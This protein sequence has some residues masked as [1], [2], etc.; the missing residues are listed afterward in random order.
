M[1]IRLYTPS[2]YSQII[3][4]FRLNTPGYFSPD[5]EESLIEYL[6]NHI[7]YHYVAE[8]EGMIIGCGGYTVSKDG[9]TAHIAWDIVHP[10]SHGKGIGGNLTSLRIEEIKKIESV[11]T[12]VVRTSQMAYKFYEKF[13]FKLKE[14]TKNYWAPGFDL[15]YMESDM[16]T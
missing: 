1:T 12:L 14:V 13:G 4:L 9:S 7:Q 11:Q 16:R 3:E 10:D 8:I 6:N 15:Y 2:D 5:E